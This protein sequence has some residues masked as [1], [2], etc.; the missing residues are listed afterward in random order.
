MINHEVD[1][2]KLEALRRTW[3]PMAS[4]LLFSG[5]VTI[6]KYGKWEKDDPKKYYNSDL[7]A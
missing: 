4:K 6:T 3:I 1:T 5:S 7:N 2:I